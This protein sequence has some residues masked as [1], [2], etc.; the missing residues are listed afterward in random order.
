MKVL[1]MSGYSDSFI[2]GHG[3]L[4]PGTH[5]LHKPFTEE[6]FL[7]KVR[8]VL[9]GGK[10]RSARCKRS[11]RT[12]RKRNAAE[13]IGAIPRW[14]SCWLWTMTS[15]FGVLIRL[16][17]CD[18][19][20]II[21]TG[22]PEEG[23]ALALEHKP[24]AILLD[25]RMPNYSGYELLADVHGFQP[26][27]K[28]PGDHRQRRGRR[29]NQGTLQA[30]GCFRVFRKAHRLRRRCG[31]ALPSSP[32]S[33]ALRLDRK[34]AYDCAFRSSCAGPTATEIRSTGTR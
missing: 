2:A 29:T 11:D 19:F 20:E 3:V 18:T 7:H 17:L 30:T 6:V 26:H 34:C 32:K 9:D 8:E 33:A 16:E 24:H 27:A 12:C 4:D 15:P 21:D 22:E 25:L 23:L 10:K 31:L 28:N 1:Y 13:P 5:L 14:I